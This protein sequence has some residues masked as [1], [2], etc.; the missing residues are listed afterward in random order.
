M[1]IAEIIS[2]LDKQGEWVNRSLT[3]DRLLIGDDEQE[4]NQVIVCWVATFDIIEKAINAKCHFIITH[5]NPFYLESTLL[6]TNVR[7]AQHEKKALLEKNNIAVYRCHDLW[8]LYPEYGVRDQWAQLLKLNFEEAVQDSFI[9]IATDV[10]MSTLQLAKHIT[11][12]IEPYFQYGI[13]I[14]GSQTK[15]IKRLGIGTGA[16]TNIFE[17]CQKQVDA[18]LVSDDGIDNWGAVQWAV[19]HHIPLLVVN[20]MTSEAAGMRGLKEYLNHQITG[21]EFIYEPNTY[22]IYNIGKDTSF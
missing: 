17:M 12:C 16:C 18:C 6:P 4:V 1:K 3:R 10:S 13:Q 5:E 21:V 22:G 7:I 15:N 11:E 9:R 2:C 14:I 19:D 20:H 8:D